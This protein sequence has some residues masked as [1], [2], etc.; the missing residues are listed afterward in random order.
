MSPVNGSDVATS[1]FGSDNRCQTRGSQIRTGVR[2][3]NVP[4]AEDEVIK[5]TT[6]KIGCVNIVGK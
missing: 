4:K 6:L 5:K 1:P 3:Q 2:R